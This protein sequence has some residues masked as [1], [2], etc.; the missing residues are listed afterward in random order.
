MVAGV[1]SPAAPPGHSNLW[2]AGW[3]HRSEQ[4]L[5]YPQWPLW[6]SSHSGPADDGTWFCRGTVQSLTGP[7]QERSQ[8][9][10]SSL[11]RHTCQL[12]AVA[13]G[14]SAGVEATCHV[15]PRPPSAT[16]AHLQMK[17]G[18]YPDP[19]LTCPYPEVDPESQRLSGKVD[20]STLLDLAA[21]TAS[22]GMPLNIPCMLTDTRVSP[23]PSLGNAR[24]AVR[25]QK[26]TTRYPTP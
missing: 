17:P 3:V 2:P 5:G 9:L 24:R 21:Q 25:G 19:Y 18:W 7:A 10:V 12:C 15:P 13:W 22:S 8:M 26:P 4:A 11:C 16:P 1:T 14:P 6:P 23:P 20:D